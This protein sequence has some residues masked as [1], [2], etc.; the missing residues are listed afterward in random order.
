[1]GAGVPQN[2]GSQTTYCATYRKWL[3]QAVFLIFSD[4]MIID[5]GETAEPIAPNVFN[6]Y[7]SID[8]C[9]QFSTIVRVSVNQTFVLGHRTFLNSRSDPVIDCFHSL[10]GGSHHDNPER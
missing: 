7:F 9:S 8:R 10:N 5:G 4:Q 6:Q 3:R 2:V 1:M